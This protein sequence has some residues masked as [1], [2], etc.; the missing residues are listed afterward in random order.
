M[1][2]ELTIEATHKCGL[3]CLFCSSK[4][5]IF[6]VKSKDKLSLKNIKAVIRKF[7]PETVRWS[8]GE[9]FLYLNKKIL[10]E[11]SSLPFP[12]KQTVTTNGMHPNKAGKLANYFSEIRVSILG[13]KQTHEKI[14]R[15]SGSW[16]Q[17]IQ[18]LKILKSEIG[19]KK[20]PKLLITS[21]YISRSQ[22]QEVKNVAKTFKIDTRITGLVPVPQFPKPNKNLKTSTCSLGVGDCRYYKKRL[23]LP[24]GRIIHCA[25][26]KVGFKCP[27]FK[28]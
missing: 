13:N 8:G 22:I 10:E 26:E 23:I 27:Y 12:H 4:N 11:V 15:I 2:S 25:V 20:K 9:P 7:K 21:P 16:N 19:S 6:N 1:I 5:T 24:N 28:S 18:T 17:A 14:T 3:N